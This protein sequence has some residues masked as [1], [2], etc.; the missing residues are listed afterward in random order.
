MVLILV[1]VVSMLGASD[2]RGGAALTPAAKTVG[3]SLTAT[4]VT[5][6][7]QE[8]SDKGL[9]SIRVQKAGT[10]AAV[11]FK[12]GYVASINFPYGSCISNNFSDLN[13][14]TAYRF[15]GYYIDGIIDDPVALQSLFRGFGDP[16]KATITAID[17][18]ACTSADH[19]GGAV[20]YV[21]SFTAVIGFTK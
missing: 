17:Y 19:G 11:V 7:T 6:V 3:S 12:S 21:L 5:D 4:I 9:T 2:V 16:S 14:S 13:Q 1:A 8:G 18:V 20:R 15:A 10:S